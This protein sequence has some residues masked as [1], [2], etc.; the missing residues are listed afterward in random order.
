MT[1]STPSL[2]ENVISGGYCIGCGACSILAPEAYQIRMTDAGHYRAHQV[3]P[4]SDPALRDKLDRVCPMSGA[5]ADETAIGKSLYPDIKRDENIGAYRDTYAGHVSEGDFRP[6]GSSGGLISWLATE[7]MDLGLIDAVAHVRPAAPGRDD[8]LMFEYAVSRTREEI[9]G[10]AKSRY[11]PITLPSDLFR[12][13]DRLLVIGLPCFIKAVR[14]LQSEGAVSPAQVPF[15]IGLVCG[16]LKSRYFGD[17]L[18]RQIGFDPSDV[19]TV[20][21]R[22]KLAGRAASRYGFEVIPRGDRRHE[23]ARMTSLDAHD[24]GEGQFK[25][26]AC[27]FCDDVLAECADIAVGDAW[28]PGYVD[29]HRGTNVVV[30]RHE[31]LGKIIDEAIGKGRLSLDRLTP[32]DVAQSQSSGLRHRREGLAHRLRRQIGKG[33]W[34]PSKRVAP[35]L[36]PRLERRVVYDLRFAIA[37][38]SSEVYGRVVGRGGTLLDYRRALWEIRMLRFVTRTPHLIS[39][40]LGRLRKGVRATVRGGSK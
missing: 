16:H 28:L 13:S 21:F 14:L 32:K 1:D 37:R 4:C 9:C 31:D 20:D 19:E 6:Q 24:W 15:T 38:R 11:Y 18:I 34:V 2:I 23:V 33:H 40:R 36:A 26:P 17:Y 5:G 8:G 3:A 27:D 39:S 7:L 10:G 12:T 25:N 22:H 35:K 30:V 29:D